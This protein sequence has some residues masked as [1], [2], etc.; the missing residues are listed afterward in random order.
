MRSY[1]GISIEY[2]R[3]LTLKVIIN[4]PYEYYCYLSRRCI[5]DNAKTTFICGFKS[6]PQARYFSFS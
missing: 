5:P 6:N 1:R 2:V 3:L 4:F